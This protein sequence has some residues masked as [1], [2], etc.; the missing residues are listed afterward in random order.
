MVLTG[1]VCVRQR[2]AALSGAAH[3]LHEPASHPETLQPNL[4]GEKTS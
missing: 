4:R 3:A 1:L 2:H